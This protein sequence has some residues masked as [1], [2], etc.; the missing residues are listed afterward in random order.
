MTAEQVQLVPNV[1]A[2]PRFLA[3]EIADWP[4]LGGRVRLDL[5]GGRT[6]LVGKNGAGKS[7]LLEGIARAS[8]AP[9]QAGNEPCPR[10]FGCE[11]R[12]TDDSD[13]GDLGYEYRLDFERL[14]AALDEGSPRAPARLW[15]ERCW[16]VGGHHDFFEA[17][18]G[19]LR[20]GEG[21]ALPVSSTTS[22]LSLVADLPP[23]VREPMTVLYGALGHVAMIPAGVPRARS[24]A[25]SGREEIVIVAD[26]TP[27]GS[28]F[29]RVRA[30]RV[31]KLALGLVNLSDWA[32]D[33]YN[34]LVAS[35][36]QLGIVRDIQIERYQD[37][38]SS[39]VTEGG[40][41]LCRCSSTG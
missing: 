1:E 20:Y 10:L 22:C 6:V 26:R 40:Q 18:G 3:V 15:A 14:P 30:D 2:P 25:S 36:Q 7:L 31:G 32:P 41:T 21:S 35:L 12:V 38:S 34:E 28:V 8:H 11:L 19:K 5:A 17:S 4:G 16:K 27:R 29:Y 13:G 37:P 39:A 24:D 9:L 33:S 23:P